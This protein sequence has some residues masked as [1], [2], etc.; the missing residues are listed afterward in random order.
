M[1]NN[2]RLIRFEWDGSIT[3]YLIKNNVSTKIT[4][5]PYNLKTKHL[6]YAIFDWRSHHIKSRGYVAFAQ[7]FKK[8]V[9]YAIYIAEY[10]YNDKR[11]KLIINE[12]EHDFELPD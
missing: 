10:R 5:E 6:K 9:D 1:K 4:I 7:N 2:Y 3:F 8:A 12:I 11:A